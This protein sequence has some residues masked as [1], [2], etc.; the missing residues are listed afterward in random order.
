MW[1]KML[2]LPHFVPENAKIWPLVDLSATFLGVFSETY[3]SSLEK[4]LK[5]IAENLFKVKN[6]KFW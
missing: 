1:Q 2:F 5:L 4:N 3:V 6:M